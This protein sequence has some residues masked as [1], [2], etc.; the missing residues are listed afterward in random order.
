MNTDW[1][2]AIAW[3]SGI[4]LFA[5]VLFGIGLITWEYPIFLVYAAGAITGFALLVVTVKKVMDRC[6]KKR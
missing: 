1:E 2:D 6:K 5:M 4:V 3:A